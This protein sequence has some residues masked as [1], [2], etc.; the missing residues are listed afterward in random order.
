MSS[1]CTIDFGPPLYR[2]V[3]IDCILMASTLNIMILREVGPPELQVYQKNL[4]QFPTIFIKRLQD[5][6]EL[7]RMNKRAFWLQRRATMVDL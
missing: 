3:A 7:S 1:F 5:S 4:I 6:H 2:R